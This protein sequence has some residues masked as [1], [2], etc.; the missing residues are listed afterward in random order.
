MR[1]LAGTQRD[2]QEV[3]AVMPPNMGEVTVEIVE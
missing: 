3:L 1:M 2:T